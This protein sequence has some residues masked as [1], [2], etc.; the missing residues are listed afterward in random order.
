MNKGEVLISTAEKEKEDKQT[1][2]AYTE[3]ILCG[4]KESKRL[5]NTKGKTFE[6]IGIY[7]KLQPNNR[8]HRSRMV[9]QSHRTQIFCGTQVP[10]FFDE[11]VT[12]LW[13]R[14]GD[15]NLKVTGP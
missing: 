10:Y 4:E 9:C 14:K 8:G 3:Y 15:Y 7:Q 5:I 12:G 2:E 1:Q 6:K 13:N 11:K